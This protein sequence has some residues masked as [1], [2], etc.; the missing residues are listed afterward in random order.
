MRVEKPRVNLVYESA[1]KEC[2]ASGAILNPSDYVWLHFASVKAIGANEYD[3]PE[4][5][6]PCVTVRNVT[7][8]TQSI[9]SIMWWERYGSQW[10]SNDQTAQILAIAFCMAH[11]R[12]PDAFKCILSKWRADLRLL[13]WQWSISATVN[14]LAWGIDRISGSM[15][16]VEIDTPNEVKNQSSA[17][18]GEVIARLCAT[19]GNT[20]EYYLYEISDADCATL[21]KNIPVVGLEAEAKTE[22]HTRARGELREIIRHIKLRVRA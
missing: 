5:I 2:L 9:A 16:A 6:D 3:A 1:V 8:Y 13:A 17:E 21:L 7:L 18:W 22:A 14:E 19:Y 10:Y 4:F 15:D 11:S 12:Q 20:P